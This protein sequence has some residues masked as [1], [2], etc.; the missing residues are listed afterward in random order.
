MESSR[1][2][3]GASTMSSEELNYYRERARVERQ[4]AAESSNPHVIEIHEKLA[5]LYEKLIELEKVHQ[6]TLHIAEA[7]RSAV[8]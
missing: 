2:L 1:C 7:M 8:A 4:R 6:P 5:A 3:Q